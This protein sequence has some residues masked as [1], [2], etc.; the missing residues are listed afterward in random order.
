LVLS[1]I[2]GAWD[3]ARGRVPNWACLAGAAAAF[4]LRGLGALPGLLAL[5]VPMLAL[6][7]LAGREGMGGGDVKLAAALGALLGP[8]PGL[9]AAFL[10]H[11]AAATWAF[12]GFVARGEVRKLWLALRGDL[13]MAAAGVRA[14]AGP[15]VRAAAFAPFGVAGAWLALRFWSS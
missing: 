10:W 15:R 4:A 6:R 7:A 8:G 12:G 13:A 2:A 11:A 5:L 9:L 3:A 14:F 1:L